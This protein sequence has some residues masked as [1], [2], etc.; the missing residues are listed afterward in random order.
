MSPVAR[1]A[2]ASDHKFPAKDG[3]WL[4]VELTEPQL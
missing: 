3:D 1:T 2:G 4:A